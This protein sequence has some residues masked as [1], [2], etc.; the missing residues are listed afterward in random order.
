VGSNLAWDGQSLYV[1][2]G[3][4]GSEIWRYDPSTGGWN[5]L[6]TTPQRVG[7]GASLLFENGA[8]YVT[9]GGSS[10]TVWRY[11]L[12]GQWTTLPNSQGNI[13][14]GADM[15]GGLGDLIY[16]SY[17]GSN[18][19]QSESYDPTTNTWTVRASQP[20]TVAAGGGLAYDGLTSLY[21]MS[22]SGQNRFYLYSMTSN[23]WTSRANLPAAVNGGGCLVYAPALTIYRPLGTF[24]SSTFNSGAAGTIYIQAFWDAELPASTSI[25]LEVRAS[26]RLRGG[27][28][29]AAWRSMG[30]DSDGSMV[31]ITGRY[32][33]WRV[34]LTTGDISATPMLEEVRIYY[35]LG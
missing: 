21:S 32:V 16:C 13:G 28:P 14:V 10:A 25:T 29:N 18:Q 27:A 7:T 24:T 35:R 22:G 2:R 30:G 23:S 11:A 1:L 8:L 9:R 5:N 17:G 4:T 6:A 34:T 20:S 19:R 33:Q 15:V 12:T 31:G 26:D 3:S